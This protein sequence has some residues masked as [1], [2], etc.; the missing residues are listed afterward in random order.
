[1]LVPRGADNTTAAQL[2]RT[3]LLSD[4]ARCDIQP[5]LEIDTDEVVCT[6]GATVR[7]AASA[8]QE[9]DGGGISHAMHTPRGHAAPVC[10]SV[11]RLPSVTLLV[12]ACVCSRRFQVSDLDDEMIFY[13]QSRGLS[14]VQARSLLLAGWAR[15]ALAQVPSDS[16]K[17]RA[18]DK[19]ATL[20]PEERR[21]SVRREGLMSI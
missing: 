17:E 21:R 13:L 2:C 15:D 1:M 14:R 9:D 3:L 11:P 8:R 6:H 12:G 4:D 20:A 19:A 10:G 7:A 18:A 5:T 16:A